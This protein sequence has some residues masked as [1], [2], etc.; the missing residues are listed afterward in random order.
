MAAR[1]GGRSHD[2]NFS[3]YG[4]N[5]GVIRH[6]LNYHREH[7]HRLC[8][9]WN[10]GVMMPSL[11]G[12]RLPDPSVRGL[13]SFPCTVSL[14]RV[15]GMDGP[16]EG[17]AVSVPLDQRGPNGDAAATGVPWGPN[18]RRRLSTVGGAAI[19]SRVFAVPRRLW[20]IRATRSSSTA[21]DSASLCCSSRSPRELR[22]VT[23]PFARRSL[24]FASP[25][26]LRRVSARP[27]SS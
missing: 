21:R 7:T 14:R 15:R 11:T 18:A 26:S 20:T 24:F 1:R 17:C 8:R 4:F 16:E 2:A 13:L 23:L 6:D 22:F 12:W 10:L 3:W 27:R 25:A 19:R 9:R 5:V